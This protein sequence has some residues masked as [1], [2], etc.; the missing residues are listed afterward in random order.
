MGLMVYYGVA[1]TPAV[2]L[3]PALPAAGHGHGVGLWP[4]ALGAERALP[5]HQLPDPFPGADLD[6][7]D[8]G[9]LWQHA[10]PGALPLSAGL[11]PMT[12]VVE[13]FRWALL[14][15]SW[16]MLT[17]P[18]LLFAVSIAIALLVLVSGPVFFRR[19]ERTFADMI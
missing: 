7:P 15:A 19:T 6:V 3:L 17:P 10:D 8:A 9:G 2:L 11:N 5:R 14:G 13:G 4:V 16:P 12:G 18:G 1:P